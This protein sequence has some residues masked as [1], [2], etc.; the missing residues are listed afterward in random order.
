[1]AKN[2]SYVCAQCGTQN[3]YHAQLCV[4]C[5]AKRPASPQLKFEDELLHTTV[6]GFQ[7]TEVIG[8]GGMGRVYRAKNPKT[9]KSVA[10]KVLLGQQSQDPTS[11]GRF[12][13]E[14]RIVNQIHHPNIVE[15]FELNTLPDGRPYLL[16]ELLEGENFERHLK[17]KKR[18]SPREAV[19]IF[20]PICEALDA[21]HQK[22]IVHRDLK[23]ENIFLA[24]RGGAR[25]AK[26]L[27]FGIAKLHNPEGN[28]R[29]T[30][31]GMLLGTPRYMS[32]EQ[33]VT[34]R[35]VD[36]RS[37][38][39]S[40][41]TILY[42]ALTGRP[43]FD[44]SS[45]VGLLF[46]HRDEL[47]E[48]P[49]SIAPD[50]P[51]GLNDAI[52]RC[53]EKSPSA[54][55]ARAKDLA[56][57]LRA[58]LDGRSMNDDTSKSSLPPLRPEDLDSNT[59]QAE[60][61]E[62]FVK[63]NAARA[64]QAA[65]ASKAQPQKPS[66]PATQPPKPKDDSKKLSSLASKPDP[67]GQPRGIAKNPAPP[68]AA[69]QA[70][71]PGSTK[72]PKPAP[73]PLSSVPSRPKDDS[74]KTGTLAVAAP[75]K[76]GSSL[77]PKPAA[78]VPLPTKPAT[79]TQPPKPKEDSKKTPALAASAPAQSVI[80]ADEEE[81]NQFT[82]EEVTRIERVEVVPEDPP[83]E[84]TR[85]QKPKASESG[86]SAPV[87]VEA[88]KTKPLT[89]TMGVAKPPPPKP[90]DPPSRPTGS[91]AVAQP[92]RSTG[93][94]TK[95]APEP[96]RPSVEVAPE[97]PPL[98]PS[99]E[100]SSEM[101]ESPEPPPLP[102]D[103]VEVPARP[104]RQQR[105]DFDAPAPRAE[106][107]AP[108]PRKRSSMAAA[109]DDDMESSPSVVRMLKGGGEGASG[110]GGW[111]NIAIG[112]LALGLVGVSIAWASWPK[113]KPP[114]VEAPSCPEPPPPPPPELA[115]LAGQLLPAAPPEGKVTLTL[116]LNPPNARVMVFVNRE[117]RYAKPM[118]GKLSVP[119]GANL[120]LVFAAPGYF[121][122]QRSLTAT[123][124]QPLTILLKEDPKA[125]IKKKP[126]K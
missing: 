35:D 7:L 2:A 20:A 18:L 22:K 103:P 91:L 119:K 11:V 67:K 17:A 25:V 77:A 4:E 123:A 96:A 28:S 8:Q 33:A 80:P 87:R 93:P 115:E 125:S 41:G 104:G 24:Q 90:L 3:P 65:Q 21:A 69:S 100:V 74:R 122:D 53:L 111:K 45:T 79:T 107:D 63:S 54:R 108:Q 102:P 89:G 70:P 114:E 94:A 36:G 51:Q 30:K 101:V 47:P 10:V 49:K 126:G 78:S 81:G 37:D 117:W 43:P 31:S 76:P 5:G 38:I 72:P 98:P 42:E 71:K 99:I 56:D 82:K 48:A 105:A 39:Y 112:A 19:E 84:E 110:G 57:A 40:V 113:P 61:P 121:P 9:G 85:L 64:A 32:P 12:F 118:D 13:D 75:P 15:V 95:P 60:L 29:H 58:S 62:E 14:A 73:T 109:L 106:F 34:P 66:A 6:N 50:L 27:D 120:D 97:P 124:D 46:Q 26:L 23:P 1:M 88:P 92:A 52:V 116:S 55:F 59:Q 68:S 86:P 83:E 16:M 44:G